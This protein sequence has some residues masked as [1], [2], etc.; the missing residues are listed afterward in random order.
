M[1]PGNKGLQSW[2]HHG[3]KAVATD[4]E[5][6]VLERRNSLQFTSITKKT[7]NQKIRFAKSY[8]GEGYASR[9]QPNT[10]YWH[11]SRSVHYRLS[12][13]SSGK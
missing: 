7:E 3:K 11:K 1:G 2:C 5:R 9:T 13:L 8:R 6:I 10:M 4:Q 12:L